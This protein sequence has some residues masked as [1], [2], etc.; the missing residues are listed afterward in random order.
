MR[1]AGCQY[2][3]RWVTGLWLIAG[4]LALLYGG[5]CRRGVPAVDLGPKPPTANGTVTGMVRGPEGTSPPAG[6][7]IEAVNV[8]TGEMRSVTTSNTGGFTIELP[9]GKYR[10][11]LILKPGEVLVSRPDVVDLDRGDIDS[12]IEFVIGPPRAAHRR[13]AFRLDNGLG[14]P[15]A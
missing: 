4:L 13:P 6:R 12:H 11:N 10:L 9:K 14:S 15:V 2:C 3:P 8:A 7:T 5:A 1:A